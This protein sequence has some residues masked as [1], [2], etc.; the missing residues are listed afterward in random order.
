[1][2]SLDA[3]LRATLL[4][5]RAARSGSDLGLCA[6]RLAEVRTLLDHAARGLAPAERARLRSVDAYRAALEALP[7][8]GA[9]APPAQAHDER[10]RALSGIVKRL[11]AERRLPRLY[12]IVLES[13]I[14]LSG[15]E[16][17]YLVMATR[18]PAARA[19]R[20]RHRAQGRLASRA[21]AVASIVARVLGSGR[22]LTTMDAASD[23]QLSAAAS[24]HALSLRSVL[25]VPLAVRGEVVGAL[26]LEDRLRPFAFGE[27]ELSLV[28]DLADL[29]SNRARLGATP[30]RRAPRGAPA[31][32]AAR[33][34]RRT[35]EAR[36]SSSPRSSARR[37]ARAARS[38]PGI[39]AH[40]RGMQ[41]VLAHARQGR[42]LG[43]A[44][45]DQR[46]ERHR[47]GAGRARAST[48]RPRARARPFVAINCGALPEPLLESELFGHVRGAFT[49]ADRAQ[50]RPVRGRRRR[51][52]VPRRDRR[53]AARRCRRS[54]CACCR[55]A[56]S[57]R[58]AASARVTVDVRV[59]SPRRTA[60]SKRSVARRHASAR[61]ST[62][63]SHV[64]R[65][66]CR[67]CASAPRTSRCSSRTSCDEARRAAARSSST[68]RRWR[69]LARYAWPGNVR[70]LENEIRRALVL[71]DDAIDARAPLA[72]R[73][74]TDAR[75]AAAD[76]L[77]MRARST[78]SSAS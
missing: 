11:T 61:T 16:R 47:Q 32:R 38:F 22:A 69:A 27:L 43:R 21:R 30:A 36:R 12:E 56:R 26:D 28:S 64:V 23:E 44:G 78:S 31:V 10:W 20:A 29:A 60:T 74:S 54:C 75:A 58:S 50:A 17:G 62:T 40:S 59:L 48:R 18:R 5:A 76:P 15:A 45:A 19:R 71:A 68:A 49:G 4:A 77:D 39:I 53:D 46:R 41:R 72:R 52:A 24:V 37:S 35:V 66:A 42:A 6:V 3:R 57:G 33:G 9:S 8:R 1:M 51:H 2:G 25:A 7:S 67:R 13:A 73:W 65:S 34:A 14:E 55:T 70:E 63:G